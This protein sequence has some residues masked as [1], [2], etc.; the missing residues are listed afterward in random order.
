MRF[1]KVCLSTITALGVLA[2][3]TALGEEWIKT[4]ESNGIQVFKKEQGD[5][6]LITFRGE[7]LVDASLTKVLSVFADV[8]RKNE[9]VD[10]SYNVKLLQEFSPFKNIH[11]VAFKAPRFI[12][13]RDYIYSQEMKF[14]KAT[15]TASVDCKSIEYKD[16]P[17]TVGVR[18]QL[19]YASYKFEQ[20]EGGKKTYVTA[21][22]NTDLKGLLPK[23]LVNITQKSWPIKTLSGLREQVKKD[24]KEFPAIKAEV[25]KINAP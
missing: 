12:E 10:L 5:N 23:W 22:I 17:A 15:K 3:S 9:W 18:A 7:G 4:G 11:Y 1:F 2:T 6:P 24:I 16:A 13:D 21:E 25:E 20:R 8:V 19:N 14:D